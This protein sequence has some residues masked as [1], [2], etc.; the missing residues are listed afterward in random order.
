MGF[1]N[2][3]GEAPEK[4]LKNQENWPPGT[5]LTIKESPD[6]LGTKPLEISKSES[7]WPLRTHLEIKEGKKVAMSSKVPTL[8]IRFIIFTVVRSVLHTRQLKFGE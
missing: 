7:N 4:F 1:E 8:T 5:N 2:S 6:P 3:G